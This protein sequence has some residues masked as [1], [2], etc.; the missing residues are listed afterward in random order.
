[1]LVCAYDGDEEFQ[2]HRVKGAIPLSQFK[3]GAASLPKDKEII[4]YCA[5][6]HDESSRAKAEEFHNRGFTNA[7]F[8][9]GGVKAWN[10]QP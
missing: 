1:V 2:E 3:S 7:R 8:L 6:P 5:C 10:E 9:E 4:F